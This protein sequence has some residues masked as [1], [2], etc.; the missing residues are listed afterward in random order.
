MKLSDTLASLLW[1]KKQKII[2]NYIEIKKKIIEKSF[3]LG[4]FG[5]K[6]SPAYWL[7]ESIFIRLC[8]FLL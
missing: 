6:E 7:L 4:T 3:H 2:M 8:D 1:Q 5:S